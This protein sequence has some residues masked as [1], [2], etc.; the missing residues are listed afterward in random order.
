MRLL[1]A[2]VLGTA[3]AGH[4]MGAAM[5]NLFREGMSRLGAAVTVLTTDGVA[6]RHGMTASAVCSVTDTP[7]TLLVCVNT[8]NRSHDLFVQNGVLCVNVLGPRHRDLSGQ[9]AGQCD[10]DRFAQ[11][12]WTTRATG[13][14]VLDD[15][16]AAF[17]CRIINRE[18][19]GTHSVFFCQVE[20]IALTEGDASGLMWFGRQFHHLPQI[21]V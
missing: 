9:F 18:V 4:L 7:P 13:A 16:V 21:A 11:G 3:G 6:G 1:F 5:Q 19:I 14:P 12:G 17:D 8:R 10:G 20:D 2:G 15:A